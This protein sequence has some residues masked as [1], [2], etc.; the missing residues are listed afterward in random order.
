[1]DLQVN[2][3]SPMYPSQ[4]A[5]NSW[6]EIWAILP[7]TCPALRTGREILL[8]AHLQSDNCSSSPDFEVLT[9]IPGPRPS[10]PEMWPRNR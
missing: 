9:S 5:L 2:P 6:S 10:P 1:M 3:F 7:A 8:G 4:L